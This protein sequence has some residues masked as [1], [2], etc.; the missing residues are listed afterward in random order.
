MS[1]HSGVLVEQVSSLEPHSY[2]FVQPI[3][4]YKAKLVARELCRVAI[5]WGELW[6]EALQ[7]SGHLFGSGDSKAFLD[8]FQPLYDLLQVRTLIACLQ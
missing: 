6:C 5:S 2:A 8:H 4:Y 1:S 3:C 7:R